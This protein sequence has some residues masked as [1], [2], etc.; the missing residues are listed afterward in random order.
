MSKEEMEKKL[1]GLQKQESQALANLQAIRGARQF[2]EQLIVEMSKG[3]ESS[4]KDG[5]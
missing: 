2:C 4:P 5:S 1:E 3:Q